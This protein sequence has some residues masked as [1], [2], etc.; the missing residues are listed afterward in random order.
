MPQRE[1]HLR[2]YISVLQKY[3]FII[4]LTLLLLLGTALVVSVRLP[5]TYTT[6][7]LILVDQPT[8]NSPVS[9]ASVV[10]NVLSGGVDRSE[11][12]TIGQRFLSESIL[13]SAIEG[14]ED[15]EIDGVRFLPSIGKIRRNLKSKSRPDSQYIE[16]S[17][18]LSEG[19]GGERN[20][21]LLTNQLVSEMQVHRSEKET[22]S[23]AHRLQLL[24]EKWEE[25]FKLVRD[26]ENQALKFVR[27]SGG[28]STWQQELSNA[29]ARRATLRGQQEQIEWGIKSS[30]LEL[31]HL[32]TESSRLEWRHLQT[33]IDSLDSPDPIWLSQVEGLVSLEIQK[34]GL[35]ASGTGAKAPGMQSID[36]QIQKIE[37][38]LSALSAARGATLREQ[39]EHIEWGI[40]SS[41]LELRNLQTQSSQLELRNLQKAIDSLDGPDP[42]WLSQMQR[43]VSLKIQKTGLMASGTGAKAPGM[44]SIDAQIQKI[45]EEMSALSADRSSTSVASGVDELYVAVQERLM[46]LQTG[47]LRGEHS[48]QEIEPK[49]H[50]VERE[51][52]KL[53]N[54][55]PE[56]QLEL[57]R[58]K[59]EIGFLHE[60]TRETYTRILQ[61]EMLL[62]ESNRW[63]AKSRY[64]H[65]IGGLEI[66]DVAVPRKIPTGPRVKFIVAIAGI[67]GLGTGVSIALFME[68]FSNTYTSAVEV[69]SD[70]DSVY[71]GRVPKSAEADLLPQTSTEDYQ[72]VA[73]NI[74]LSNPEIKKQIVM[75]TGCTQ[76]QGISVITANLGATLASVKDSVLIVD[77]NL[78]SSKQHEI[79]DV[80]FET[81]ELA[82]QASGGMDWQHAIQ[83]THIAN[84]ELLSI[85][86]CATAPID[87]RSPRLRAFFEQLREHY[88]LILLDAA[89]ILAAADSIAL[90]VQ[91]DALVLVLDLSSTTRESLRT[92]H[93]RMVRARIPLLGFIEI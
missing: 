40:K 16:L 76:H 65:T 52:E 77:C 68:Y 34:A 17:L 1:V 85:R 61:A 55:I 12:E 4:C 25:L 79:F 18:S 87:L 8:S 90:G 88:E 72:E 66:V 21:A 63:N 27:E 75:F 5:K 33:A 70:L 47:I 45:E 57:D 64:G 54:D 41:Q 22:A 83:K 81:N 69:E 32:Q 2:D 56:D 38:E 51:L 50:E 46:D 29:F 53:L 9:S 91:S 3:D 48:L 59:R 14:L 43:L 37:D 26:N 92:A 58:L 20:A 71:L 6:S 82:E 19:E 67:V 35:M 36:A 31:R 23:V 73:A 93:D 30:Q 60:L 13:A 7:T 10:Q 24:N 74:D 11:M 42:I 39:Q 49:S 28:P 80:P 78:L 15:S 44:Q 62:S 86:V 89:P 84:V